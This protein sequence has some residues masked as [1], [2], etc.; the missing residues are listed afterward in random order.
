MLCYQLHN[1]DSIISYCPLSVNCISNKTLMFVFEQRKRCDSSKSE[2]HLFL[3]TRYTL[4]LSK[5][6]FN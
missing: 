4:F 2:P 5:L 6:V 1:A 3:K